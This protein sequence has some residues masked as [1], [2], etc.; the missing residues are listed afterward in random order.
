MG[1]HDDSDRAVVEER[2]LHVGAEDTRLYRLAEQVGKARTEA[3]IRRDGEIGPRGM[4]VAW[5]IAFACAGHQR[6]LAD[7]QYAG[8]VE[9]GDGVV[10]DPLC[11]IEDAHG[12]NFAAQVVDIVIG[13]A[14]LDA[15]EDEETFADAAFEETVYF[16]G[17]IEDALDYYSHNKWFRSRLDIRDWQNYKRQSWLFIVEY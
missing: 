6:E 2:H 11:V 1:V 4:N 7:Y 17:S 12:D 15:E 8:V 14:V 3:F 13:V 10:H 9:V 16:D 5:A